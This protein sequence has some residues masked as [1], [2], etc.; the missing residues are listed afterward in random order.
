MLTIM[1]DGVEEVKE[2]L[3][4]LG[5]KVRSDI[6]REALITALTPT[7]NAA[8]AHAPVDTGT[9]KQSIGFR[10]K[11]YKRRTKFFAVI[12]PRRGFRG[13]DGRQPTQYAHIIEN[14]RHTAKGKQVEIHPFMRPAW[15]ETKDGA[16]KI[17]ANVVG[18][19]VKMEVAK[20]KRTKKRQ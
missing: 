1:I 17:M 2:N 8:R 19:R 5:N 11:P 15:N 6:A 16:L 3:N 20:R 13:P 4:R 14:G 7:V 18:S 9:L 12:G 10:V